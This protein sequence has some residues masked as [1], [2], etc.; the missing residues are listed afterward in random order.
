MNK[1]SLSIKN[2]GEYFLYGAILLIVLIMCILI[3]DYRLIISTYSLLKIHIIIAGL[4]L[5]LLLI[6]LTEFSSK[7]CLN[8]LIDENKSLK[9]QNK[10]LNF[11]LDAGEIG[12]WDWN[13][14]TN[15]IYFSP[16][17]YTMLGYE[18][19]EYPMIL[20]TWVN[21]MHPEDKETVVNL[22]QEYVANATQYEIEFRL[23]CKDGSWKWISGRGK[24]YDYDKNGK[25]IRAFGVH[26]NINE[27]KKAEKK[28]T[29][30]ATITEQA[31]EGIAVSDFD[32]Y[33]QY[34]N[35]SWC[36]MHGYQ[37][38][39]EILG[40]NLSIF[41]SEEQYIK[42]VI[43]FNKAV[44]KT[45]NHIGE[46]GHMRK[47][48]TTF[49]TMMGTFKLTDKNG[50]AY[51]FAGFAQ[52][53]TQK[54]QNEEILYRALKEAENANKAKTDFL[55]NMSHE[56][57]TPLNG[58]IGLAELLIDGQLT[59]E[60]KDFVLVIQQ[61]GNILLDLV[62]NILSFSQIESG[63]IEMKTKN[64]NLQKVFKDTVKTNEMKADEKQ[65]KISYVIDPEVPWSLK[66]DSNILIQILQHL[67]EN[68]IKFTPKGKIFIRAELDHE[69]STY[70]KIRFTVTDTG[71]G[72]SKDIQDK[73]FKPFTQGDSSTTKKF[74]GTGLGLAITS[75]LTKLL[76]G[77]IGLDSKP[78]PGVSFWF[79]ANFEK[80]EEV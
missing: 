49:P 37:T 9:E 56:L 67:I 68:A 8:H 62:N 71:I 46:V 21:L 74:N 17:Y 5:I 15:E 18:P 75:Q 24:S 63:T 52:D 33:I 44:M 41:H 28:L 10:R 77:E 39:E 14:S 7:S 58:I 23:K 2:R 78:D 51:G 30:L 1:N 79:T 65:I 76:G 55:T 53:I 19:G 4:L 61:S 12:F 54:K 80:Q 32:G 3:F 45:G 59:E 48:G 34:A 73:L 42:D 35:Q 66:G 13:L 64:F 11:I 26:V 69:Y 31:L 25:A 22:V 43:P 47:D 57:R 29:G 40:K 72:I 36:S 38:M 6:L 50:K 60:Q 16:G 27:Q 70:V 20:E